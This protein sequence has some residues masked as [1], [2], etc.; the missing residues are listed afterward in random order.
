MPMTHQN[1]N[2]SKPAPAVRMI[3]KEEVL[4][5]AGDVSFVTV[6]TWMQLGTFPRA[7]KVGGHSMWLSTDIDAWLANLPIRRIKGDGE[8]L[9]HGGDR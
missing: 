4:R 2:K 3:R 9:H 1:Q 7:R 6:W 5:I 8:E